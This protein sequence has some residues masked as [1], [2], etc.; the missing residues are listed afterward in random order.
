MLFITSAQTHIY[1]AIRIDAI[2]FI[3]V[4]LER[5]PDIIVQNWL[6]PDTTGSR[7]LEGY[8]SLL[9]SSSKSWS[10]SQGI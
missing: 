7:V 5:A 3:D 9:N 1:P 2:R 10:G 8:L 6:Q 4:F